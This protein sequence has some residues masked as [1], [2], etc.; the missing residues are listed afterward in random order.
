M[1]TALAENESKETFD[2]LK[3]KIRQAETLQSKRE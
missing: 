1:T 3:T 2:Q